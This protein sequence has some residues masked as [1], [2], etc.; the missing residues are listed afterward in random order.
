MKIGGPGDELLPKPRGR[1]LER[2]VVLSRGILVHHLRHG[3]LE[4]E[5]AVAAGRDRLVAQMHLYAGGDVFRWPDI[6]EGDALQ[7]G[8]HVGEIIAGVWHSDINHIDGAS[9]RV[10][11]KGDIVDDLRGSVFLN[12]HLHPELGH[13]EG[14]VLRARGRPAQEREEEQEATTQEKPRRSTVHPFTPSEGHGYLPGSAQSAGSRGQAA[15]QIASPGQ[16]GQCDGAS[17]RSRKRRKAW[18]SQ[19]CGQGSRSRLPA[20]W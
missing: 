3:E 19:I 8:A 4:V 12:L 14:V 9:A 10:V 20:G 17:T 7:G 16:S 18:L 15:A 6:G 11:G 5:A 13:A 1:D 2:G